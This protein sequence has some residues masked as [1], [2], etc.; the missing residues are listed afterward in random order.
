MRPNQPNFSW[1]SPKLRVGKTKYGKGVFAKENIK[2]GE[3][4]IVF[5]GYVMTLGQLEKQPE[6]F[7]EYFYQIENDL[8]FGPKENALEIADYLNHSC[9]PNCGFNGQMFLITMKNIKKGKEIT[10]DYAMC[11][12]ENNWKMKCLCGSKNCRGIITG[13]DWKIKE[14]Q[15]KYKG[16][17]QPYIQEKI[18]KKH[19]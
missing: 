14:L 3:R 1:V 2:K 17:F 10:F 8:Y 11:T 18:D 12:T 9:N 16:Y 19:N 6:Y 7:Q 5:G 15:K 13:D 4:V